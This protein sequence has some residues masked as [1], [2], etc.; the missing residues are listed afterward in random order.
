MIRK[1]IFPSRTFWSWPDQWQTQ[2]SWCGLTQ[3]QL[4][5]HSLFQLS[6]KPS[7]T[8]W[9]VAASLFSPLCLLCSWICSSFF[10]ASLSSSLSFSCFFHPSLLLSLL[11]LPHFEKSK[12]LVAGHVPLCSSNWPFKPLL[13]PRDL[14]DGL[15]SKAVVE[16][17]LLCPKDGNLE[18]E[19]A[20]VDRIRNLLE[21]LLLEQLLKVGLL[22]GRH[23]VKLIPISD[24]IKIIIQSHW[25]QE[26]FLTSL[27]NE[28]SPRGWSQGRCQLWGTKLAMSAPVGWL[29]VCVEG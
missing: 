19:P 29:L 28:P 22:L 18:S 14:S 4:P 26:S 20:S 10:L 9:A 16:H 24:N 6:L 3:E 15:G 7:R 27:T 1:F 17:V 11:I 8:R 12:V 5:F 21:L 23:H 25:K 13:C 2:A